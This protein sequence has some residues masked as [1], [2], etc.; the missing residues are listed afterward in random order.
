[1]VDGVEV[2]NKVVIGNG[3]PHTKWSNAPAFTFP[4]RHT[5]RSEP[6]NR[7]KGPLGQSRQQHICQHG[8]WTWQEHAK[9]VDSTCWNF[10][11][12]LPKNAPRF[13]AASYV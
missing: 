12:L 8:K 13:I 11:A 9:L 5:I 1:M 4:S 2:F 10:H 7:H 6:E 3:N